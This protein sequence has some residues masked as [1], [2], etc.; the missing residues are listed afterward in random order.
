MFGFTRHHA[1]WDRNLILLYDRQ[2]CLHWRI[3]ASIFLLLGLLGGASSYK[4][5][6]S[7][8]PATL[9]EESPVLLQHGKSPLVDPAHQPECHQKLARLNT[10]KS[11]DL[12]PNYGVC[13]IPSQLANTSRRLLRMGT[14]GKLCGMETE[15]IGQDQL[16]PLAGAGV[17]RGSMLGF[18]L[19]GTDSNS[20][21]LIFRRNAQRN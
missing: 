4:T 2:S 5:E 20:Y 8:M 7:F 1:S 13:S 10:Q 17:P 21:L 14:S 15:T 6:I 18:E 12:I 9:R 11:R 16:F 3:L 19:S